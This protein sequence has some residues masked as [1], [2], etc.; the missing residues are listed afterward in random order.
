V[1]GRQGERRTGLT[2][3]GSV[4]GTPEYMAPEQLM[5]QPVDGRADLYAAGVVLYECATG[6][7]LFAGESFATVLLKQVQE[8][9][10]DPRVAV[11]ALPESFSRLV[12]RALAKDP[13]QR[14][15]SATEFL[16]ELDLIR[17]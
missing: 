6:R 13:G 8:P 7:R 2:A 4:I 16:R 10:P 17:T 9:P 1:E 14:C 5:G 11:P 15:Q 12:L 3:A